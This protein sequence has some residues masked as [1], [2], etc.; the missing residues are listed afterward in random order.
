MSLFL[1][2]LSNVLLLKKSVVCR[3]CDGAGGKQNLLDIV[4]QGYDIDKWPTF[5]E[6]DLE[7]GKPLKTTSAFVSSYS[8]H[9][10]SLNSSSMRKTP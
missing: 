1:T 5:Q 4:L 10:Y 8:I 3:L 7:N 2:S 6:G 9:C